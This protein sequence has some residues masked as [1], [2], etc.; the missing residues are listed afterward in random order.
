[1]YLEVNS[2]NGPGKKPGD[3]QISVTFYTGISG[4]SVGEAT[5][6]LKNTLATDLTV[7]ME[8]PPKRLN[9]ST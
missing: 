7:N 8:L 3:E 5:V 6:A 9:L 1:M 4:P 2:Q